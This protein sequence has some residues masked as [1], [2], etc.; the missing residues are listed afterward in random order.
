MV[1]K[2][3]PPV[4]FRTIMYYLL[5]RH[6]TI[7]VFKKKIKKKFKKIRKNENNVMEKGKKEKKHGATGKVEQE[8]GTKY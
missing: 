7:S 2:S 1:V 8:V 3:E 5:L 6:I 4:A